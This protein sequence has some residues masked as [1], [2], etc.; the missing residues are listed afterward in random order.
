MD[1]RIIGALI[2]G[3]SKRRFHD[4]KEMTDEFLA[5]QL[6]EGDAAGKWFNL[7][8]CLS[9]ILSLVQKQFGA[10]CTTSFA[11]ACGGRRN[12]G[13]PFVKIPSG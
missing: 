13:H 3:L 7:A 4:D 8:L 5:E 2:N 11:G 9:R 1:P 12:G 10:D 6:F